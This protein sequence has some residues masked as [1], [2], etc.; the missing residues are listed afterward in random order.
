VVLPGS[1]KHRRAQDATLFFSKFSANP[2]TY[3][4]RILAGM[5]TP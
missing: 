1:L 3:D 2:I 5:G 4:V